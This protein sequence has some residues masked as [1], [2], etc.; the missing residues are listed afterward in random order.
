VLEEST[1]SDVTIFKS[2]EDEDRS[3]PDSDEDG[4]LDDNSETKWHHICFDN[5]F[6]STNLT[7]ML[8]ELEIYSCGTARANRKNW[9]TEFRK[10]NVLKL[11]RG[12]SRKL[13]HKD[14]AAVVWQDKHVVLLLSINSDP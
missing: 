14:V 13:Q 3:E 7:K 2:E 5:S 1:D 8:L 4:Q 12:K 10:P 9:P 11:K 6:S